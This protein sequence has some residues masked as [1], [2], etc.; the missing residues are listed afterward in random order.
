M[1]AEEDGKVSVFVVAHC[2]RLY[3]MDFVGG[4][5]SVEGSCIRS[6]VGVDQNRCVFCAPG[7]SKS[8]YSPFSKKERD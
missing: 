2:W 5:V 7:G 4:G 1:K 3:V 6:L 8:G